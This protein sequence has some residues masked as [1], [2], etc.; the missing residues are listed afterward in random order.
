MRLHAVIVPV[1]SLP[2]PSRIM[3]NTSDTRDVPLPYRVT[4][5]TCEP[6]LKQFRPVFGLDSFSRLILS[7]YAVTCIRDISRRFLEILDRGRS[8]LWPR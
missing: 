3:N 7:A 2:T 4:V 1:V 5:R 6:V 8:V